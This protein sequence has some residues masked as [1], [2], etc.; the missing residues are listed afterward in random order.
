MGGVI[1]AACGLS[2]AVVAWRTAI[3]QQIPADQ[4]GRV[5]A[6]SD[7]AEI[8]LTPIGYLMVAPVIREIGVRT[9]LSACGIILAAANLAPLLN[10]DVRRLTLV[11]EAPHATEASEA[12]P[13]ESLCR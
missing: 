6:F 4:Q 12:A 1:V 2:M 11:T 9:T 3:Q 13:S 8:S 7:V 10:G 5:S